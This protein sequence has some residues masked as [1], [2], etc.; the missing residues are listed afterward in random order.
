V[1]LQDSNPERRNL[2]VLSLSIIVFYLGGGEFT[3]NNI[4]LQIVNIHFS[5]PEVLGCFVWALLAWFAFRYWLVHQGAWT[6]EYYSD[7]S[8]M[9][10]WLYETYAIKK[11]GLGSDYSRSYHNDRHWITVSA[12]RNGI[13]LSNI[14]KKE[15]ETQDRKDFKVNSLVRFFLVFS[16]TIY[17][18]FKKPNLTGVL[19]TLRPLLLC[20][21]DCIT[22]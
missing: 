8:I 2:L 11:L 14:F 17:I 10:K 19:Y 16:G 20:Y 1:A 13:T 18:L 15:D 5:K 6:K 7:L 9:P 12:S 22:T 3:D 21:R 4:R